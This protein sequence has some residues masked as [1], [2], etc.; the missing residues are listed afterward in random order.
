MAGVL[1]AIWICI[2]AMEAVLGS[3]HDKHESY[4]NEETV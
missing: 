3:M 1:L 4:R 2:A